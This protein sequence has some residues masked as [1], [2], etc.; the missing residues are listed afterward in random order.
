MKSGN[1][2]AKILDVMFVLV[3]VAIGVAL[4]GK[5]HGG[6]EELQIALLSQTPSALELA[7]D[8]PVE[9]VPIAPPPAM[10]PDPVQAEAV[11]GGAAV[12][13]DVSQAKEVPGFW[14]NNWGKVL[15]GTAVAYGGAAYTQDWWP[16]NGGKRNNG[17]G[18]IGAPNGDGNIVVKVDSGGG[19]V[20]VQINTGNQNSGNGE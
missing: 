14:A 9:P 8:V 11:N 1:K 19:P 17:S 10:G 2:R 16:F 5:A 18:D 3:G 4:C 6:T 15:T 13:V 20:T 7:A 12:A